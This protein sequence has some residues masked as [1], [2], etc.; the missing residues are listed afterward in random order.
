MTTDETRTSTYPTSPSPD[1]GCPPGDAADACQAATMRKAQGEP[2][3]TPNPATLPEYLGTCE[4][5]RLAGCSENTIRNEA[6]RGVLPCIQAGSG[7][8]LYRRV[9][10]E[11][12]AA[13]HAMRRG[14]P[15]AGR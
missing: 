14:T 4:A 9:D 11:A 8:R 12:Y 3:T 6:A 1:G 2:M 7:R 10:V 13:A 5:A 15:E